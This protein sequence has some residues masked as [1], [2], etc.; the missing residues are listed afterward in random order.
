MSPCGLSPPYVEGMSNVRKFAYKSGGN[1][2]SATLREDH[3]DVSV[4]F[5]VS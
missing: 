2:Y 3:W 5:P 1:N 4:K